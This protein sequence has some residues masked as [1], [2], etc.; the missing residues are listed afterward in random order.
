MPRIART[1]LSSL[2]LLVVAGPA[3]AQAADGSLPSLVVTKG[4][5]ADHDG[6][7]AP[8]LTVPTGTV[9][10]SRIVVRNDGPEVVTGITLS[11]TATGGGLPPGCAGIPE[12][13]EVGAS[14]TCIYRQATPPGDTSS[15]VTASY[16]GRSSSAIAFVTGT[17]TGDLPS[18]PAGLASSAND[19]AA[20]APRIFGPTTVLAVIGT[21]V[22][23]RAAFGPA[24]SGL[25]IGVY[26]ATKGI[27]G[28]W[29][30]FERVSSRTAG[31]D[32]A[33]SF[34]WTADGPRWV[35]VRFAFDATTTN[36]VQAHWNSPPYLNEPTSGR[37]SPRPSS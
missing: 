5:S 12:P 16:E 11:D 9:L 7:F 32:G 3:G 28:S 25:D 13:L 17:G 26:M 35:S 15:I 1:L 19:S 2:V 37:P 33:V 8:S 4:L 18:Q 23:W 10:W 24:F 31:H 6:A 29:G 21:P 34:T 27:D 30:P 14:Y 22:T 36:A 20:A